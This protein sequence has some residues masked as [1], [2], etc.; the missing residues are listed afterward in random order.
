[1]QKGAYLPILSKCIVLID[2]GLY[3]KVKMTYH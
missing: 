2:F 3:Q 1:M